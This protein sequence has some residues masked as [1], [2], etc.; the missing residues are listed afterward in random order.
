MTF[1]YIIKY[2][3]KKVMLLGMSKQ[4][5]TILLYDTLCFNINKKGTHK[6]FNHSTYTQITSIKIYLFLLLLFFR[7]I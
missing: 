5:L 2:F 7:A 4:N 1:I 3:V 6:I